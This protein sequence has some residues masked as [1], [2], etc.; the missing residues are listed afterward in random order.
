MKTL[1]KIG[2]V[3]IY[4]TGIGVLFLGT[5]AI[6]DSVTHAIRK[7]KSKKW[8]DGYESGKFVGAHD[9]FVEMAKQN[10]ELLKKALKQSEG[11]E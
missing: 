6:I 11:A 8:L 9:Q 5:S 10:N 2:T 7:H 4:A 1:E 3:G